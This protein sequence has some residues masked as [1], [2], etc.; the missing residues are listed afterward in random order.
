MYESFKILNY[1]FIDRD[2]TTENVVFDVD[3]TKNT[4]QRFNFVS[5]STF[6]FFLLIFIYV[7]I[8]RWNDV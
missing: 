2:I 5:L 8:E 4:S 1:K 6:H 7:R 3:R